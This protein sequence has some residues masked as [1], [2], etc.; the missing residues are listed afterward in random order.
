V[1]DGLIISSVAYSSGSFFN[2]NTSPKSQT[3]RKHIHGAEG[4]FKQK[5]AK[6]HK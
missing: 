4:Q 1:R 2:A 5:A 6:N 3:F